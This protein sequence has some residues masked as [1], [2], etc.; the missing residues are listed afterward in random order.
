MH[1][2][3]LPDW[4][5][6]RG[7]A[8]N[9]ITALAAGETALV[10][11]DMQNVF[12]A[13]G[14]P[15]ANANARDILGQVNRLTRAMRQAGSTIIWTRQTHSFV[16]P[17]AS[18]RGQY[19]LSR[20]EVAAGIAAMQSGAPGH[21]LYPAMNVDAGDVVVDKYR[22][23]ALSCPAGNLNRALR[24]AGASMV[25]IAGTLTNC[26]VETTA[27]ELN[28]AGYKVIVVADA[29][30]ATT[31]IEQ[32]AALINLRVIFA[33]VRSVDEVVAMVERPS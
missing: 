15:F 16:G 19:D 24:A 20:P 4:A 13:E 18:P 30:A 33:D 10:N 3:E 28:M 21:Q 32:N 29:T 17:F 6:E 7:R 22:Y 11:I 2:I 12:M 1:V 26:C 9:D 31:D 27:R 25:V 23:G 5:V 8:F 14:M